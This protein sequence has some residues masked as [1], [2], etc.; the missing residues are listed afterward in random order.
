[1]PQ[2][3][4]HAIGPLILAG[5]LLLGGCS[6]PLALR[7]AAPTA[8][9]G[10]ATLVLTPEFRATARPRTQTVV[11]HL[12][13]EDV[14]HVRV[15]LMRVSVNREDAVRNEEGPLTIRIERS[16]RDRP[17][18]LSRLHPHTHY[19]VRAWA[20]KAP[21]EV[22][23]NLISLDSYVDV[24]VG[25][26]DRPTVSSLLVQLKDVAFN[27]KASIPAFDIRSGGYVPDGVEAVGLVP[28][29]T[30]LTDLPITW[31]G[32]DA[33]RM[34]QRTATADGKPDAHLR[35]ALDLPE[36]TTV[37]VIDIYARDEQGNWLYWTTWDYDEPLD[38]LL[39]VAHA[40]QL[41]NTDFVP[42]VGTFSGPTEFDLFGMSE[43]DF[44][45]GSTYSIDVTLGNA[46][47]LRDTFTVPA[48]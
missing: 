22:E 21:D 5:A 10:R 37:R 34:S 9:A 24:L 1:M 28:L 2:K 40:D 4:R 14:D 35:L 42:R 39:G 48:Q 33:D 47:L 27:G 7:S 13:P 31:I 32:F 11:P 18:V 29:E 25:D 8:V 19:R 45:P 26:D 15:Q 17:V 30:V 43:G 16:Q 12:T 38:R 3:R 20:Y 46:K 44:A 41:L 23:E 6:D 36:G